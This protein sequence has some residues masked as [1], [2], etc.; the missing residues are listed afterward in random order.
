MP[1]TKSAHLKN[2]DWL[3]AFMPRIPHR[4]KELVDLT[5]R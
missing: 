1:D 3:K 5:P 4:N 2:L